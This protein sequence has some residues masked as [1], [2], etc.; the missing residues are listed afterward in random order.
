MTLYVQHGE[1]HQVLLFRKAE[2]HHFEEWSRLGSDRLPSRGLIFNV[3]LIIPGSYNTRVQG[4]YIAKETIT[5]EEHLT[6]KGEVR[7]K[8]PIT[9]FIR[10]DILPL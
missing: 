10:E 7:K 1:T 9:V 5:K 2:T 8:G 3:L 4:R 6:Q